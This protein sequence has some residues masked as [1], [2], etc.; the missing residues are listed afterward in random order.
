ML[1]KLNYW[2]LLTKISQMDFKHTIVDTPHYQISFTILS[3]ALLLKQHVEV[4][5]LEGLRLTAQA[6]WIRWFTWFGPSERNTLH[7]WEHESCIVMCAVQL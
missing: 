5:L 3:L 4:H 2:P 6:R 1:C 7:P